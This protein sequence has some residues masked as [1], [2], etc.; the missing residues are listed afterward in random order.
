MPLF[1][2]QALDTHGNR[3]SGLHESSTREAAIDQLADR[4]LFVTRLEQGKER[5]RREWRQLLFFLPPVSTS[6]LVLFNR[7]LSTLLASDI[8]LL[9]S[10]KA[11]HNQ[12]SNPEFKTILG[13]VAEDVRGGKSFSKALE[14]HP[15]AFPELM[16]SMVRVGE[17][18]GILAPVL[19]ELAEFTERDNQIRTDV[20]TALAYP[21]LVLLLA[22]GTVIFLL[23]TVI[24]RLTRLFEGMRITLPLPTR[25]LMA[26]SE[27]FTAYGWILIPGLL[28]AIV[29]GVRITRTRSGKTAID[30]FKLKLPVFGGLVR[31]STIARFSRSLGAL[32]KGGVPLMEGLDVVNRVLGNE[33]LSE[34]VERVKECVRKGDSMAKGIER[35]DLFPDMVK[36]MVAA[37]EDSGRLDEMLLKVADVYE[38][39]TR[40]A[41]KVLI[42]LLAPFLILAVA[43]IVGFIAFAM[44]LPIF[45]INQTIA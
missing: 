10:L 19:N 40:Q 33:V 21:S 36:Y 2:Y 17:S 5:Q 29:A 45:Q 6:D 23:A 43:A 3:V 37:G 22:L 13:T 44:L 1:R 38:L 8:P 30:R 31:K 18:G 27:F 26:V 39:E 35:E 41:I 16:I 25:I 12:T 11:I 20:R 15:R 42:D 28:I 7:R 34:S 32:V 9:E 24:P 14:A 4:H